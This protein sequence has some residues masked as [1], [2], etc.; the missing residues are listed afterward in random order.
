MR[1]QVVAALLLAAAGVSLGQRVRVVSGA[2]LRECRAVSFEGEVRAGEAFRKEFT[3]GL[4]FFLEPLRSGWIVRVLEVR[5]GAEI[6]GTHDWAEVAT[7][8][9][10]S[11]SPLLVSTDWAFRAQDA[12]AWNPREFRYAGSESAFQQM[13][14]LEDRVVR[15]DASA[16][17][18]DAELASMQPQGVL[19]LLDVVLV[20]GTRDQAGTAALVA[21]HLEQTPH[22]VVQGESPSVLGKLVRLRFRVTLELGKGMKP[23][24]GLVPE[25]FSCG[26]RPTG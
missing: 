9:Y 14:G 22:E 3:P 24:A 11:V 8:P 18:A 1:L 17:V 16:D 19:Q 13:S 25:R 6:R 4:E 10:R 20:P 21:S 26:E 12:A 5:A 7:P 15:N 23:A 2:G